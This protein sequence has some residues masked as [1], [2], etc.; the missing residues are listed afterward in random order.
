MAYPNHLSR[1]KAYNSLYLLWHFSLICYKI[2]VKNRFQYMGFNNF[3]IPDI[4]FVSLMNS[5]V[6]FE[7]SD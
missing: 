6:G 5:A 7:D 3:F 4:V 2:T 1:L